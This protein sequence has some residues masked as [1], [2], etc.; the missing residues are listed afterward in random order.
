MILLTYLLR[1]VCADV[2]DY[3]IYATRGDIRGLYVDPT[4]TSQ[5]FAPIRSLGS[6]QSFDVNYENRTL[7]VVSGRRLMKVALDNG[8]VTDLST[9][10]NVSGLYLAQ[11]TQPVVGLM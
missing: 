10:A 6:V 7:V 4:V 5:P 8:Q 3:L 2:S 9:I 11:H 1:F